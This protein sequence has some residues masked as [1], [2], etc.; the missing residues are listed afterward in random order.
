MTMEAIKEVRLERVYEAPVSQIWE[1]WTNPDML[2][3]W[4]GPDNVSIPACEVDLR[5]GGEFHIVMEAGEAMGPYKGTLW[6]MQATFT[7][8]ELHKRLTYTAQAW[9]EGMK[10]D[11]M[12]DQSTD[13]QF[14]EEEGKTT[15]K[16][17]AAIYK[18][19]PSA[20][21]AAEGMQAG[22]GQQ[23]EKLAAFL[24]K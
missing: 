12:I 2:K 16:V 7:T 10:E 20:G 5:V 13:I 6:P 14:S 22:F 23:F 3:A 18:L 11:T 1:A 17:H 9:T 24:S 4:W 15:V 19:G 21:M 8:V